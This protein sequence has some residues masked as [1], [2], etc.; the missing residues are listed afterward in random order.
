MKKLLVAIAAT[1]LFGASVFAEGYLSANDVDLGKITTDRKEEDGFVIH[2][3]QKAIEVTKDD[4]KVNGE[5]FTQRFKMAGAA[6]VKGGDP[7]CLISFPASKGE[8][9]TVYGLSSSKTEARVINV[10]DSNK[11]VIKTLPMG[12]YD[13]ENVTVATFKVPANGT[14]SL[15]SKSS[16]I[17]IYYINVSK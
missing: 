8:T 7:V 13:K 14:Y 16:T 15:G 4:V 3:A 11:E 2:G 12:V 17:Y 1:L 6:L 10:Y 5:T 9:I